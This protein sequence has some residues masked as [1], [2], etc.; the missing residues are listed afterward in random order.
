MKRRADLYKIVRNLLKPIAYILYR[1][2]I[3][4]REN[5]N[6]EGTSIIIAN[7][8][9]FI[10]AIL[11]ACFLPRK[12]CF[13]GKAELF[14]YKWSGSLL[15]KLGAFPVKRGKTDIKAIKHAL[16][17]LKSGEMLGIFPEGTRTKNGEQLGPFNEGAAVLAYR[18]KASIITVGIY[19]KGKIF[20]RT[21]IHVGKAKDMTPFYQEENS[22]QLIKRMTKGME[23][24]IKSLLAIE[25]STKGK[26]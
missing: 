9:A 4:G 2:I 7:H 16:K 1:P 5:A 11:L 21:V 13:M 20:K 23:N 3:I 17:L 19:K 25:D 18:T 24:D 6:T 26:L 14:K 8:T 22:P 10:D 12:I 15:S